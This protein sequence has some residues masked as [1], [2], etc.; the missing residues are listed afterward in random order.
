MGWGEGSALPRIKASSKSAVAILTIGSFPW[1]LSRLEDAC[2]PAGLL[3]KHMEANSFGVIDGRV[4]IFFSQWT[5]HFGVLS[6]CVSIV[7]VQNKLHLEA[8]TNLVSVRCFIKLACTQWP[9]S[10][11]EYCRDA[12]SGQGA[13]TLF[14]GSHAITNSF[15]NVNLELLILL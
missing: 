2:L 15:C 6:A 14:R 7:Q 12:R 5:L 9:A 3:S 10:T 13:R 1:R 8:V 11:L 4:D